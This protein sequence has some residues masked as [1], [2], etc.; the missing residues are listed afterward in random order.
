MITTEAAEAAKAVQ[1]TW[2]ITRLVLAAYTAAGI[3]VLCCVALA[4]PALVVN[5]G[6]LCFAVGA[7]ILI[8]QF[9]LYLYR[10]SKGKE[11]A[12]TTRDTEHD[13]LTSPEAYYYSSQ[14]YEKIRT[15][16]YRLERADL[17]RLRVLVTVRYL[18]L[19]IAG[20]CLASAVAS[21]VVNRWPTATTTAAVTQCTTDK[22]GSGCSGTWTVAGKTYSAVLWGTAN[23]G[24]RP[25]PAVGSTLT[26]AYNTRYPSVLGR[27]N[28]PGAIACALIVVLLATGLGFWGNTWYKPY[29]A[30]VDAVAA[31]Q[32]TATAARRPAP[33]RLPA[34]DDRRTGKRRRR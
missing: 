33:H 4:D 30:E 12:E 31:G 32:G 34:R 7:S 3:L 20:F 17:T 24:G 29:R 6:G 28:V 19:M 26:V 27:Q 11:L 9:I 15:G 22:D 5:G 21:A 8:P 2:R 1:R 16:S 13:D 23:T 10:K 18:C 14:G 25:E